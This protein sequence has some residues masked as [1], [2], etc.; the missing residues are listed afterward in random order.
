MPDFH[1]I[2]MRYTGTAVIGNQ[3]A[4]RFLN[5]IQIS[6]EISRPPDSLLKVTKRMLGG[7]R[8][9]LIEMPVH[10]TEA[11][12]VA[13]LSM[14][15]KKGTRIGA[16]TSLE[17]DEDA[18]GTYW[19]KRTFSVRLNNTEAEA[20]WKV[21]QE[22]RLALSVSFAFYA[23]VVAGMS[24]RVTIKGDSAFVREGLQSLANMAET[25]TVVDIRVVHSGVLP[26]YVDFAKWPQLLLRKDLNDEVSPA[27]AMLEARCY[28]FSNNLR[29]DLSVKVL[30]VEA[31][32][33][34]DEQ[35][36]IKAKKFFSSRPDQNMFQIRFPYAVK[37]TKPYRYR[38]IEY[39]GS[40][41]KEELP[42]TWRSDWAE[43]LD[44]T[45]PPEKNKLEAHLFEIECDAAIFDSL[46][47]EDM[48]LFLLY[49]FQGEEKQMTLQWQKNNPTL[50]QTVTL[51]A[52]IGEPVR[53][54]YK[55]KTTGDWLQSPL[56]P[57]PADGYIYIKL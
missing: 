4:K 14:S 39:S 40:G 10:K 28:D 5:L 49:R 22:D 7:S 52:D 1:L 45:T 17:D 50:L 46:G 16:P 41:N 31:S 35:V 43:V 24:G 3:G 47:G 53:Y 21:A 6:V 12:L 42:W 51:Y 33:V 20:L 57:V 55:W 18:A 26:I 54:F 44:V 13:P 2:E 36:K 9:K 11:F 34:E 19:D 27:F 48:S 8:V 15:E 29:P 25:D 56:R 32:G 23:E 30:E 37:L 38:I